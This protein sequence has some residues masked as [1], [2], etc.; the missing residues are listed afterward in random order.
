MVATAQPQT[1][2]LTDGADPA[3][4][5]P[6]EVE[7]ELKMPFR[8]EHVKWKPQRVS[9]NKCFAICYVDARVVMARLDRVLGI[10]GWSDSFEVL[11]DGSVVCRLR[12]CVAGEWVQKEDVGSPSEQPDEHDRMKAA[13]SDALKRAASKFGVG[14]YLWLAKGLWV[15]Y[16][17]QKRV[18]L[19]TPVLPNHFR[20]PDHLRPKAQAAEPRAVDRPPAETTPEVSEEA[21]VGPK[22]PGDRMVEQ[23]QYDVIEQLMG[24]TGVTGAKVLQQTQKKYKVGAFEGF[25]YQVADN[26]I[27][28][29]SAIKEKND[30]DAQKKR[31]SNSAGKRSGTAGQ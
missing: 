10:S 9:G 16:D 25:T 22:E 5:T 20:H 21:L 12:C 2:A 23:E 14:R 17:P 26:V 8:D 15:D 7:R 18:I 11:P 19:R 24:A 6:L 4:K 1:P 27:K 28:W 31:E 29:L 3:H 30:Q 13:F